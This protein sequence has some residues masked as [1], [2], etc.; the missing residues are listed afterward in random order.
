[1]LATSTLNLIVALPLIFS[2]LLQSRITN[3]IAIG[4]SSNFGKHCEDNQT[5]TNE[6]SLIMMIDASSCSTLGKQWATCKAGQMLRVLTMPTLYPYLGSTCTYANIQSSDSHRTASCVFYSNDTGPGLQFKRGEEHSSTYCCNNYEI[7]ESISVTRSS[8]SFQEAASECKKDNKQLC[9]KADVLKAAGLLQ[10][11]FDESLWVSRAEWLIAKQSSSVELYETQ[12]GLLYT[13]SARHRALCCD[14]ATPH[15]V[16]TPQMVSA[17]QRQTAQPR[18]ILS[19]NLSQGSSWRSL[20]GSLYG[21]AFYDTY[22]YALPLSDDT[23]TQAPFNSPNSIASLNEKGK[24]LIL[25]DPNHASNSSAMSI[26]CVDVFVNTCSNYSIAF[27]NASTAFFDASTRPL[28][29]LAELFG[30]QITQADFPDLLLSDGSY[31]IYTDEDTNIMLG[32]RTRKRGFHWDMSGS[33]AASIS[34]QMFTGYSG[35]FTSQTSN[36][37]MS[38]LSS[39]NVNGPLMSSA[40]FLSASNRLFDSGLGC[41]ISTEQSHLIVCTCQSEMCTYEDING[42]PHGTNHLSAIIPQNSDE[43]LLARNEFLVNSGFMTNSF[44]RD[45]VMFYVMLTCPDGSYNG[46]IIYSLM[47]L[48]NKN[49]HGEGESSLDFISLNWYVNQWAALSSP[50]SPNV[51]V[52]RMLGDISLRNE[53]LVNNAVNPPPKLVLSEQNANS[54]MTMAVNS[55]RDT[56]NTLTN[57][58]VEELTF[59]AVQDVAKGMGEMEET[60]SSFSKSQ[61]DL[62]EQHI[63]ALNM[64]ISATL[65]E[66]NSTSDAYLEH[67]KSAVKD[68]KK[69]V[70]E[71][72]ILEKVSI[73]FT[74]F[75]GMSAAM[76]GL[77]GGLEG[78][79][80]PVETTL[81][82][83]MKRKTYAQGVMFFSVGMDVVFQAIVA[84]MGLPHAD[85]PEASS[86]VNTLQN[87]VSELGISKLLLDFALTELSVEELLQDDLLAQYSSTFIQ[88]GQFQSVNVNSCLQSAVDSITSVCHKYGIDCSAVVG[89]SVKLGSYLQ[90]M[91]DDVMSYNNLVFEQLSLRVTTEMYQKAA[92]GWKKIVN[93]FD[94]SEKVVYAV[95]SQQHS[96]L[97]M[98]NVVLSRTLSDW[99]LA[100]AYK[101]G[102]HY[103]EVNDECKTLPFFLTEDAGA[104]L[105]QL[106]NVQ[107]EYDSLKSRFQGRITPFTWQ[108]IDNPNLLPLPNIDPKDTANPIGFDLHGFKNTFTRYSDH[109]VHSGKLVIPFD[110]H[111]I[112]QYLNFFD[113]FMSGKLAAAKIVFV[114]LSTT[115]SRVNGLLNTEGVQKYFSS[116]DKGLLNQI[117]VEIFEFSQS[118]QYDPNSFEF[119]AIP[120][121]CGSNTGTSC[122]TGSL[123]YPQG[124]AMP[125]LHGEFT[126]H[127]KDYSQ[128][129]GCTMDIDSITGIGFDYQAFTFS[130]LD[131]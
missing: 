113:T 127:L 64:T 49:K 47:D 35:V 23:K 130:S 101:Y 26:E 75:A 10:L 111:W 1:M 55:I 16:Q 13:S 25:V 92:Q 56:Y 119:H 102:I 78:R 24:K 70:T 126:V 129:S 95:T 128:S 117:E 110:S 93:K 11:D 65:L 37:K 5:M 74:A 120:N 3:A 67:M 6:C 12:N 62:Q 57:L 79:S 48:Y 19:A 29:D 58:E 36:T 18:Y 112:S 103:S 51:N 97:A 84:T 85:T 22:L 34:N 40:S 90:T 61:S 32:V 99:C 8:M 68:I 114:G 27:N 52:L 125:S 21:F 17:E 30:M 44:V 73:A 4:S 88:N 28:I 108:S 60:Y 53:M 38:S 105:Y 45:Q 83:W 15:A 41:G 66:M 54:G 96:S 59:D 118:I 46:K 43:L 91:A 80:T 104:S 109:K 106:M 87:S 121:F 50:I 131:K 82:R 107:S 98:Q 86:C 9:S 115:C 81:K 116:S 63:K 39:D 7:V 20:S 2:T 124:V 123:N 77:T 100:L 72:Q 31:F 94:D 76:A 71:Q 122:S 14:Y 69:A 42:M 89:D 33:F